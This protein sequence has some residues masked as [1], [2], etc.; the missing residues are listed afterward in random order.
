M[1]S[2]KASVRI[3][4][5]ASKPTKKNEPTSAAY[6]AL[7]MLVSVLDTGGSST[8]IERGLSNLQIQ[9]TEKRNRRHHEAP[10]LYNYLTSAPQI[11]EIL[12]GRVSFSSCRIGKH[13]LSFSRQ[14]SKD[15]WW[16]EAQICTELWIGGLCCFTKEV[17]RRLE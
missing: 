10:C 15:R 2:R 17:D 8:L 3:L 13:K 12:F 16:Q 1:N 4:T 5:S 11:R 6:S 7:M 9:A 14:E